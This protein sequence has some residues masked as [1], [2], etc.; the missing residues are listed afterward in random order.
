MLVFLSDVHLTDGIGTWRNLEQGL[1]RACQPGIHR[2]ARP[3][4]ATIFRPT[5]NRQYNFEVWNGALG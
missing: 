3:H 4:Y 5:E 2:L 1:L